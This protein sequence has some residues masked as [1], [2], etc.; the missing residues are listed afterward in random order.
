MVTAIRT[1][2]KKARFSYDTLTSGRHYFMSSTL[3]RSFLLIHFPVRQLGYIVECQL[4][5]V[6][7][8]FIIILFKT[9]ISIY[10]QNSAD[11][12]AVADFTSLMQVASSLLA[13]SSCIK[14]VKI[15]LNAT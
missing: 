7:G 14:S 13:S 8:E 1:I 11:L 3:E 4:V 5:T 9:F 15:V 6:L 12:M 2:I 10:S